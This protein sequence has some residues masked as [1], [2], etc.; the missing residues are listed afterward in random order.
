MA[1][2]NTGSENTGTG[3]DY[4]PTPPPSATATIPFGAKPAEIELVPETSTAFISN[5]GD[6]TVSAVDTSADNV[7]DVGYRP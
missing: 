6:N 3:D 2:R 7:T 1:L 4:T 5:T